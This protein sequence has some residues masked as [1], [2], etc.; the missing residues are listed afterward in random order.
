MNIRVE[1]LKDDRLTALAQYVTRKVFGYRPWV[2]IRESGGPQTMTVNITDDSAEEGWSY[3]VSWYYMVDEQ[4]S[5]E[6]WMHIM[7]FRTLRA[8]DEAFRQRCNLNKED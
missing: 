6:Q 8:H 2:S 7:E 4:L 3:D 5:L 1:K